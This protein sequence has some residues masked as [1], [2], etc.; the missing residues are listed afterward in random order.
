MRLVWL[1]YALCPAMR[2]TWWVKKHRELSVLQLVRYCQALA[3]RWMQGMFQSE[4]ALRRLL[5]RACPTAVRLGVQ[6]SRK[7]RT[8]APILRDSLTHHDETA[9][10]PEAVNA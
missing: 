7:R 9:V 4:L 10:F 1:N 6:A 8:T 3:A 5:T 2:A